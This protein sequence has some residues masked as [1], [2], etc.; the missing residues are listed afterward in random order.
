VEK[1]QATTRPEDGHH[2]TGISA[3][4]LKAAALYERIAHDLEELIESSKN[5]H[6]KLGATLE[7]LDHWMMR[8]RELAEMSVT[9][10]ERR[11][12]LLRW[13]ASQGVDGHQGRCNSDQHSAGNC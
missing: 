13:E 11:A 3:D 12:K 6:P 2:S 1:G 4:Q 7:D 9:Y 8:F 10:F 5:Y